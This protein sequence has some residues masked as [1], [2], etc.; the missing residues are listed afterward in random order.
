MRSTSTNANLLP[1]AVVSDVPFANV[2]DSVESAPKLDDRLYGL[3]QVLAFGYLPLS[4][5]KSKGVVGSKLRDVV[6]HRLGY[7]VEMVLRSWRNIRKSRLAVAN[8]EHNARLPL[9]LKKAGIGPFKHAKIVVLNCWLAERLP[10]YS[11]AEREHWVNL[12]NRSSAITV[13][14]ENQIDILAGLGVNRH[15]LK[16][17]NFGVNRWLHPG[18]NQP[19]RDIDVLAVGMDVGRD[20]ETLFRA[21]YGESWRVQLACK[22][23]NLQALQ[24]PDNV[25]VL[26]VITRENYREKLQRAKIVVVPTHEFAYPTGQSVALEAAM[27][28]AAVVVTST[29]PMRQYFTHNETAL[30][31][32]PHSAEA[33]QSAIRQL[34]SDAELRNRI[35]AA[36]Q[37]HCLE[38]F[39]DRQMWQQ[40]SRILDEVRG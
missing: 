23:V 4:G 12:L 29:E 1:L 3:E 26:G 40:I 6:E 20:Y 31:P 10:R 21:A 30:M 22:P 24:I 32:E 19:D 34:L 14:S 37:A 35:A 36:G 2:G 8:L 38:N 7:P 17:I 33:L 5:K 25:S 39:T 18:Q 9:I 11:K 15:L 27:A 28:G 13:W 16:P